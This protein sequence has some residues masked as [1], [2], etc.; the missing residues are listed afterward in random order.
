MGNTE[1]SMGGLELKSGSVDLELGAL[2][3]LGKRRLNTGIGHSVRLG[4]WAVLL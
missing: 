3:G 1:L 2:N 4:P